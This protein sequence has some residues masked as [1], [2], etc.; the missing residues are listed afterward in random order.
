MTRAFHALRHKDGQLSY[1]QK[2]GS[3]NI[4][5]VKDISLDYDSGKDELPQDRQISPSAEMITFELDGGIV[6][7]LRGSGT[8]PKLKYYIEAKAQSMSEAENKAREVEL[9]L[10]ALSKVIGLTTWWQ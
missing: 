9:A 8:E 10:E 3:H 5:R 4:T 6:M 2:L 1:I 7:T